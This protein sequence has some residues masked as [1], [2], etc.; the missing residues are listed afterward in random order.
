MGAF[1]AAMEMQGDL[2]AGCGHEPCHAGWILVT[3][4]GTELETNFEKSQSK[5][6]LSSKRRIHPESVTG[7]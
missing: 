3:R 7:S 4:I 6:S 1:C 2:P 5:L